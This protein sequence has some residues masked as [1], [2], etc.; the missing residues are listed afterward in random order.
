MTVNEGISEF[1]GADPQVLLTIYH[2]VQ[3]LYDEVTDTLEAFRQCSSTPGN[4]VPT[5]LL[6]TL[7]HKV[8]IELNECFRR[9]ALGSLSQTETL[10]W[11]PVVAALRANL[12]RASTSVS[13]TPE[14][15]LRDA[16]HRLRASMDSLDRRVGPE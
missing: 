15:K 9:Q 16:V 7:L 12:R 10:H 13:A 2:R 5:R 11:M 6:Q 4:A 8:S 14:E 3:K 1:D